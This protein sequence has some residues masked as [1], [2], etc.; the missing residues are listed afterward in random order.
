[1]NFSSVIEVVAAYQ[2]GKIGRSA[3]RSLI[4]EFGEDPDDFLGVVAQAVGFV[5]GAAIAESVFDGIFGDD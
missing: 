4:R 1:M 5:A 2:G 3:A